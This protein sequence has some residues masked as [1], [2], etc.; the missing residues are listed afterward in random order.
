MI[1]HIVLIRFRSDIES[2]EIEAA[3]D[4]VVALREKIE[5]IVAITVGGNVSPEA[6]DKGFQ[7][8]FVVDFAD[9]AARDAYLPHPDHVVVG[10]RL[11]ELADNG[12]EGI[13]VFDYSV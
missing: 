3:L 4:Q 7:H 6:L 5:G 13:L 2:S 12:I 8:G 10:T 9:K 1:R 11:V